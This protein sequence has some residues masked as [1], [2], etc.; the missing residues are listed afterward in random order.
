MKRSFPA[1]FR[2]CMI[3]SFA[4]LALFAIEPGSVEAGC[5]LNL[6]IKNPGKNLINVINFRSKVKKKAGTW[7]RLHKGGWNIPRVKPGKV[8]SDVYSAG[9]GCKT[10]RRFL[11]TYNCVNGPRK[12]Q[13]YVEYYPRH[14]GPSSGYTKAVNITIPLARCG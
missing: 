6:A 8:A 14:R 5:K 9:F 13:Q 4:M 10:S 12:G 11:I 7:R 3:S 1:F 2:T